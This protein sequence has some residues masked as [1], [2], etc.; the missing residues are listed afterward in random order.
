MQ[1]CTGCG[2]ALGLLGRQV[3]AEQG[4]LVCWREQPQH[5]FPQSIVC[6]HT[7]TPMAPLSNALQVG[8]KVPLIVR[9]EGTNVERGKEILRTSGLDLITAGYAFAVKACARVVGVIWYSRAGQGG[10]LGCLM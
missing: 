5:L 1:P 3:D 4:A 9:L 10:G 7:H 6:C 8:V 2:T